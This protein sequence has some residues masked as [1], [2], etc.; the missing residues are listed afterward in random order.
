[1]PPTRQREDCGV[2]ASGLGE[3]PSLSTMGLTLESTLA[4]ASVLLNS[5]QDN[6]QDLAPEEIKAALK[7]YKELQR[8]LKISTRTEDTFCKPLLPEDSNIGPTLFH[9]Q[10]LALLEE[11]KEARPLTRENLSEINDLFILDN[12]LRETTVG[13]VRGHTLEEKHQIVD[14]IADTGLEEIILGAFGSKISVDSQIA[15]RWTE[16]G[17][18]FDKAWGFSDAFDLGGFDEEPLWKSADDFMKAKREGTELPEYWAPTQEV[19][20]TYSEDDL[21]LFK[22]AYVNFP[23][24]NVFRGR[25]PKDIL[26]E[27]E[28]SKGRIPMGLL[29]M[30]GYG[31]CNAIIEVD[32]AVETFDYETHNLAERCENLIQWCKKYFPRRQNV[33]NGEDDTARIFVNCRDFVNYHR[34]DSGLEMCLCMVDQLCRLPPNQR[35]FGFLMEDPTGWLWPDEVGRLTRLIKLT[36][37]RAGHPDGKF[38]VHLHMFFGMAEACVLSSMCNGADGVWAALCKTGAQVGHACSTITAVNLFRAG[39]KSVAKKYNFAKMCEGARMITK[40]TTKEEC[41]EYEEVY[42]VRAFDAAFFMYT[43]P[44][45]RYAVKEIMDELNIDDYYVRLNE[46]SVMSAMER[47]MICH[48]GT[49]E[50]A[51]WDPK[52][53]PQ[54]WKAIVNHLVTGISRDYNSPL[55]LGTLYALVSSEGLSPSM[56]RTM[57]ESTTVPDTHPTVI[58]FVHRW[59][60]LCAKHLGE[61]YTSP[62]CQSK[63]IM[64]PCTSLELQ[65]RLPAIPFEAYQKDFDLNPVAAQNVPRFIQV[66][67]KREEYRVMQESQKTKAPMLYFEER[68]LSLKL[69]IQEAESLQV[70]PLVDDFMLRRMFDNFFGEGDTWVQELKMERPKKLN[71]HILRAAMMAMKFDGNHAFAR[72]ILSAFKRLEYNVGLRE[73]LQKL[74]EATDMQKLIQ[75]AKRTD[76]NKAQQSALDDWA[77]D[78]DTRGSVAY[79]SGSVLFE[80]DDDKPLLEDLNEG[81]NED[82]HAVSTGEEAGTTQDEGQSKK[83]NGGLAQKLK[84]ML[85]SPKSTPKNSPKQSQKPTKK[86]PSSGATPLHLVLDNAINEVEC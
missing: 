15:G 57:L 1:M 56:I 30:A 34:S 86:A 54:M 8:V 2:N 65:P 48:F 72:M 42:G 79:R 4:W 20:T 9:Q 51:G 12:S 35:P 53:C 45:K 67:L 81:A 31:I 77:R 49:P 46:I 66:A 3:D 24:Q 74:R 6:E 71:K 60:R 80:I 70:L 16:L 55:G 29:M 27:S 17:K 18:S 21:A 58:E 19:K 61:D 63:S 43:I 68:V 44:S 33:A 11:V 85:R 82:D 40:I 52:H 62:I 32:T 28:S 75:A 73:D 41:L 69:F 76:D 5:K 83:I 47:A 22:R 37:Q 10:F 59:N 25:K 23:K 64:M 50:D 39:V 14:A 38:L 26:K 36:M 7:V 84:K 78:F 13:S